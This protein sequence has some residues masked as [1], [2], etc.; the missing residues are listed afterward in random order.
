MG[1][2]SA[3]V[4][5]ERNNRTLL[6]TYSSTDTGRGTREEAGGEK[7]KERK[8][9]RMYAIETRLCCLDARP[10]AGRTTV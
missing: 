6:C 1:R 10:A 2:A 4:Y 7:E 8:G 9:R 3:A 5:P